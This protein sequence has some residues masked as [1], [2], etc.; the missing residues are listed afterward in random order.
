MQGRINHWANRANA[1]G[2]ALL[3]ASRLN[4]K[5][6]LYCFFMSRA[7]GSTLSLGGSRRRSIVTATL[8]IAVAVGRPCK[9]EYLHITVVLG[10]LVEGRVLN[11]D[12][13]RKI[14]FVRIINFSPKKGIFSREIP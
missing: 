7:V 9:A 10:G 2:L 4:I 5:T 12:V 1:W 14:L 13:L 6:L 11:Y 8:H 3:G